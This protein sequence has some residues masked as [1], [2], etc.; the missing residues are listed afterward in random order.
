MECSQ[1]LLLVLEGTVGFL[2][3]YIQRDVQWNEVGQ[4]FKGVWKGSSENLE[5]IE[6]DG[7]AGCVFLAGSS[8]A[9]SI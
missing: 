2:D 3:N 1:T 5:L 6:M 8:Q 7:E 4:A 9:I